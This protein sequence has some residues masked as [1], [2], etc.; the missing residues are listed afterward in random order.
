VYRFDLKD[1]PFLASILSLVLY[2]GWDA[3]IFD[4][5]L[6]YQIR[7]NNDGFLDYESTV[8][9][10]DSIGLLLSSL[11]LPELAST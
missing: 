7:V 6:T 5:A 11:G 3:R 1:G 10:E 8:P 4:A 2:F 9:G